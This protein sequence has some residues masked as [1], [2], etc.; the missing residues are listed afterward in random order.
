MLKFV[1]RCKLFPLCFWFIVVVL[2]LRVFSVFEERW[3]PNKHGVTVRANIKSAVHLLEP[4][5]SKVR[6]EAVRRRYDCCNTVLLYLAMKS[7][8]VTSKEIIL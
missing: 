7:A 5:G 4:K 8:E 6:V 2:H 3:Q 1:F